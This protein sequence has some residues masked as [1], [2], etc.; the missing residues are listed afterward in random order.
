MSQPRD[1]VTARKDPR[2]AL[3]H[4]R[5]TDVAGSEH[6]VAAMADVWPEARIHVPF[7]APDG[8]PAGLA[9][10]VSTGPLQRPYS[11]IAP[12]SYAPLLPAVPWA[13]GHA[14]IRPGDVDAVVVSHHAFALGALGAL[15]GADVPSVAY[16]HSPAR[17]AWDAEFRAK[18]ASGLPART[19]LAALSAVAKR[20]EQKWA[21]RITQPVA[22]SS[23]VK[24]RI[25]EWWNREA[26]VVHPPVDT[27]YFR[28]EARPEAAA[29]D[30]LPAAGEYFLAVGRLVPYKRVDLAAASATKAG[31]RLVIVGEGRDSDRVRS[32]AGPGVEFF[33]RRS[34]EDIRALMQGA[35]AL[36][37]PGVEDFGIV[38]VEAMA[39]GTP[40]IA[41][42][43]GG[44]LDTVV[45]GR[46]GVLV[47]APAPGK[48][49]DEY[50]AEVV[51]GFAAALRE[52]DDSAFSVA[53]LREHAESFSESA[54]R[55]RISAV[56]DSVLA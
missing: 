5:F 10:R 9:P 3:V 2:I 27:E 48:S 43:S 4:E 8:I 33:G 32:A 11:A 47:P 17:W 41:L 18:E 21:P 24:R 56:V 26:V 20:N 51:D 35:R 28:A 12:R 37:M 45:P 15:D 1:N 49:G 39:A 19:A 23:E 29:Q 31:V 52:F 22:N 34:R 42:G 40:V 44:A 16:V 14:D 25:E 46:S 54:F 30:Q 13:L 53:E 50:D 38:P 55:S 36:L 6:V 7:S